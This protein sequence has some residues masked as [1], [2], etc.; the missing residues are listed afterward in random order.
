LKY[1]NG[2][3][4]SSLVVDDF[5]SMTL[6]EH[7]NGST[8]QTIT[9]SVK[10]PTNTTPYNMLFLE[11]SYFING[12]SNYRITAKWGYS[13]AVPADVALA[14]SMFILSTL[15]FKNTL[16]EIKSENIGGYSV[17]YGSGEAMTKIKELLLPYKKIR[18]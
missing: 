7:Y 11:D 13:T 2:D 18:L 9:G 6:L 14:T 3:N 1:Y 8:W 17:S 15:N 4:S 12:V 16:T 10:Y 5:M